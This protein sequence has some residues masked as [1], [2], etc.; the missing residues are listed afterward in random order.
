MADNKEI[1]RHIRIESGALQLLENRFSV[2]I[3]LLASIAVSLRKIAEEM[4]ERNKQ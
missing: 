2:E 4:T 1:V 3:V